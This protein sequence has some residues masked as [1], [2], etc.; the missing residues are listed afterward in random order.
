MA[1]FSKAHIISNQ[2]EVIW[3]I[4]QH[5]FDLNA[6]HDEDNK[7]K[8]SGKKFDAVPPPR[9]SCSQFWI[10]NVCI[11]F[12]VVLANLNLHFS[13]FVA[14]VTSVWT[15]FVSVLQVALSQLLKK[16]KNCTV[17][18]HIIARICKIS[19]KVKSAAIVQ[20]IFWAH[21]YN[22]NIFKTKVWHTE[23]K[24]QKNKTKQKHLPSNIDLCQ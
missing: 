10:I 1:V 3:V 12:S 7:I 19:W 22:L 5:V 21:I 6:H 20:H 13:V 8:I 16:N 18:V 4:V 15:W 11:V 23:S 9:F 17:L 24:L 2:F 14:S